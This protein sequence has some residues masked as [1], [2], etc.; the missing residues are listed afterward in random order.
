[1]TAFS[2]YLENALLNATLRNVSFT[3]PAPI[4]ISLYTTDPT[5]ADSGNEVNASGYAR[6]E[7]GSTAGLA[8]TTASGG[9]CRNNEAWEMT[10]STAW[11]TITHFGIHDAT[12]GGN[13]LYYGALTT[14]KVVGTD[15]IARFSAG[16]LSVKLD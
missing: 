2:N 1:M 15:D 16:T 4:F 9:S 3:S 11:A 13:L 8:F 5:D 7:I 6:L 10:A 12:T 14:S